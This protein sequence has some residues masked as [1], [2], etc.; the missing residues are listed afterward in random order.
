MAKTVAIGIQ[1]FD[2]LI[3]GNYF[4]IDKTSFIREW[5]ENGDDVTLITRPRRFGKTLNIVAPIDPHPA[6]SR[7]TIRHMIS[8]TGYSSAYNLGIV[9]TFAGKCGKSA[10]ETVAVSGSCRKHIISGCLL[11]AFF[12]KIRIFGYV[13][14]ILFVGHV[15]PTGTKLL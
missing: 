2:K 5:W 12:V 13:D 15:I 10:G 1:S 4:Y 11:P 6:V 9:S 8:G 14:K 7:Q 3:E